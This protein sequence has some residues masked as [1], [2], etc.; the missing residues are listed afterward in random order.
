MVCSGS[1]EGGV[2]EPHSLCSTREDS[3][4]AASEFN[5]LVLNILLILLVCLYSARAP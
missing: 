5:S 1:S 2:L 3:S 4:K